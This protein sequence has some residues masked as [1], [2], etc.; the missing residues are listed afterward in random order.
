MEPNFVNV[1]GRKRY[2]Q[3]L[4]VQLPNLEHMKTRILAITEKG[5]IDHRQAVASDSFHSGMTKCRTSC[6]D[7]DACWRCFIWRLACTLVSRSCKSRR[8]VS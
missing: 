1:A 7:S 5:K 6:G 4:A 2:A 8:W 3:F